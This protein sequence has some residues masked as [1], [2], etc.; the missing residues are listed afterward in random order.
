MWKK[1]LQ[2]GLRLKDPNVC[3]FSVLLK[4]KDYPFHICVIYEN[5]Y[6]N[7]IVLFVLVK[8]VGFSIKKTPLASYKHLLFSTFTLKV[9][10]RCTTAID[11]LFRGAAGI[12]L[13]WFLDI[14]ER[15]CIMIYVM[16]QIK[17]AGNSCGADG[18]LILDPVW[19]S[20]SKCAPVVAGSHSGEAHPR[21]LA[22]GT[23]HTVRSTGTPQ[24]TSDSKST[25]RPGPRPP[26]T[27]ED[28]SPRKPG[29]EP[30]STGSWVGRCPP[31]YLAW[32]RPRMSRRT[33]RTTREMNHNWSHTV[34]MKTFSTAT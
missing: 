2:C 6:K 1:Q 5:C 17:K 4:K 9:V 25:S 26:V 34:C 7:T 18:V 32:S 3:I 29:F 24:M 10:C 28:P 21:V 14:K 12:S 30:G 19:E 31:P 8:F 13:L 23:P 11:R 27:S 16:L 22:D 15:S 20:G 33:A